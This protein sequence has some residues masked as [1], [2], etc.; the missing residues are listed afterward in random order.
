MD[1]T[2][3]H[4]RKSLRYGK[5]LLL[6]ILVLFLLSRSRADEPEI[7]LLF[8]GDILLSRN[9]KEEIRSRHTFPWDQL[10]QLFN[11]ADLVV[12]NLEGAVGDRQ[13]LSNQEWK[14][15][16]FNI[17]RSDITLLDDAGFN[18]ITLENNHSLDL[19][20]EGKKVTIE[21]LTNA[22]VTPVYVDNSPRFFTVKNV[23]ISMLALNMVL[24][25]DSS[26]NQIPSIEIEQKLRLAKSLSHIVIVSIHW[27]SELL[28]WPSREQ[29]E[30]AQ[31]LIKNG[32][33]IIIGSHPHVIQK[34]E[35]MDGKPV[36]YSLGNHLFDQ[37]Y[38]STKKGL[39]VDIR[40]QNGKFSCSGIITHTRRN[41][42]YPEITDTMD[43]V[44]GSIPY[45]DSLLRVNDYTLKPVSVSDRMNHK[46]IL[47]AYQN[48]QKV[49]STHPMSIISL[50]P[51]KLDGENEYLFA[52]E[53]HYSSLDNEINARPY[54]Y[55]LD[56]K[57]FIARWRGSA[58]A[59]PLIDAKI[60]FDENKILCALHRG[61]S[62][63]KPDKKTTKKRIAAY[64][65]NGFGFK[66]M[67]DSI[68][69]KLCDELYK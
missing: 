54:V 3:Y 31:W 18:I 12:G 51:C 7:R 9:V 49:W 21:A 35:L 67:P 66:G 16:V 24:S 23:V 37:K 46:I 59:W 41:S 19:G 69:C 14:S 20:A 1:K 64:Q 68:A 52:L 28:D 34:P 48:N 33:D 6:T 36:F 39:M 25:R 53:K 60:S 11:S 65:W 44:F 42:F 56:N 22:D 63:I 29:R 43:Y 30:T 57:G 61:D 5:H 55:G 10:K 62:F 27:G 38:P 8:V 26:R 2:L 58:L 32:A 45:R 40:I 15:P 13:H 47:Q 4:Q 50:S 17:D